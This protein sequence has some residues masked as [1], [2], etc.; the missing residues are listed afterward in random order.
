MKPT[1]EELELELQQT[2]ALLKLA[3]EEIA[4]LKEQINR[5][6]KN[7]SKPPSTDH[8]SNTPPLP[9]KQRM[10]R[11][12]I[13]RPLFPQERVDNHIQCSQ[14]NCPHCGSF[15]IQLSGQAP[16][17]MQ[18]AELPEVKA[19]VTEYQLQKYCCNA[20]GKGSTASLP[21]G[22]PDSAFGT[23]LMALLAT[24]TGVFHLAKREAIQLIK[25]LYDVDVGLGSISNIEERVA[26]ALDPI[27]HR[28]H[29]YV[30]NCKFSKHFDETGWRDQ[31]KRHFVWL[32]SCEKAAFYMIDPT[33][34]AEAFLKLVGGKDLKGLSAVTDRYA[35]YNR[36]GGAHQYCLAH[37]I[38]EFRR[39]AERDGPDKTIGAV[40][41]SE[42]SRVCR[43]H[44]EY[45]E[46]R[47][48]WGLRN[49]RLGHRKRKVE[50]LLEDGMANGSEELYKICA[51]LL[52]DFE[53]LWAFMR[54]RGMEPT[55]NLAERDLRKIVVWRKKSYGTRS[56]RGKKF[57]ERITTVA[58]TVKRQGQNILRFVEEVL[59]SF[60]GNGKAPFV[61]EA[62]G[63]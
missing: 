49:K 44:K 23:R 52:E 21:E 41:E 48:T 15:S 5:N 12:G 53:H 27:Y 1:Y 30:L 43:I 35:A 19:I 13:S 4:K 55:N 3:L 17:I 37:L 40:L 22:I 42:L 58:Q 51:N 9:P 54:V 20:C 61:S 62:L 31:G 28:I 34:S 25:N 63:F 14:A 11:K 36:I 59:G 57:V 46:G 38:R 33:R 6:S 7:S 60:Y 18:Q 45:R 24:L 2:K 16:E 56:D 32:A 8:K 29:G 39:Y 47:I 26:L 50:I 10:N